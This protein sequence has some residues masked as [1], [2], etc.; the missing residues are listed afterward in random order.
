MNIDY[1]KFLK[2]ELE[3]AIEYIYNALNTKYSNTCRLY[4]EVNQNN[5]G[6]SA[7]NII[8][9]PFKSVKSTEIE[10]DLLGCFYFKLYDNLNV[11]FTTD[12][13]LTYGKI[14]EEFEETKYNIINKEKFTSDLINKSA[15]FIIKY[16]N[17]LFIETKGDIYNWILNHEL[18]R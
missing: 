8:I 13:S 4:K 6:I 11:D 15:D 3:K 9:E 7:A 5:N 2:E 16:L 14:I 12:I 17:D 1:Q 18:T 10:N